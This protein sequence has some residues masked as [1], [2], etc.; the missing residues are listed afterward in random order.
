[1]DTDKIVELTAKLQEST[2]RL[3]K[4]PSIIKESKARINRLTGNLAAIRQQRSK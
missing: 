1:M 2:A 4:P 3:Q